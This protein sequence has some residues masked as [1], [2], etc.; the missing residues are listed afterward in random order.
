MRQLTLDDLEPLCTSGM[1]GFSPTCPCFPCRATCADV[2]LGI[3]ISLSA[4]AAEAEASLASQFN[5]FSGGPYGPT[6][7]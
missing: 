2:G 5:L 4:S 6:F 3:R 1:P 7:R